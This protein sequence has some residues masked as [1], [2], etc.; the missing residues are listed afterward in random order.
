VAGGKAALKD[1]FW[2]C[3]GRHVTLA[4]DPD[5]VVGR[6][7]SAGTWKQVRWLRRR[8]GDAALARWIRARKGR[9]LEPRQLRFWQLILH[10]PKRTVDAWLA[11]PERQTWDRRRHA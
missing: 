3:D 5:F 8:V 6:V 4:S 9:G 11:R 2:D 10:L 1:L 7:L